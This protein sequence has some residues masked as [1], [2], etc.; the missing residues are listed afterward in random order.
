MIS[1]TGLTP[2]QRELCEII[3]NLESTEEIAEWFA[4]LDTTVRPI[5]HV[6]L[7]MIMFEY[8]DSAPLEDLSQAQEIIQHIQSL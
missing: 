6:M 8:F 3:W 2:L 4:T 1:L 7:Q 5:A